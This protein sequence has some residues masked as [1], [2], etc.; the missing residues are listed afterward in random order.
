V[1]LDGPVWNERREAGAFDVDFSGTMQDP[2]PSGLA[3]G[4]SCAGTTNV[5]KYCDPVVDSL[6]ERA[7]RGGEEPARAWHEVLRRIEESSP[8]TFLYSALNLY[9]VH[10]R[11]ENV[12]I[13]PLSSWSALWRW[14]VRSGE[15]GRTVAR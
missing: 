2:T 8:A 12:S 10:R 4:W 6:L 7:M 15:P 11:Y 13:R 3:Q 9:G 1:Q 5:A 14:S